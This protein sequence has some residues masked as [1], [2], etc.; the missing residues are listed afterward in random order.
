VLIDPGDRDVVGRRVDRLDRLGGVDRG[1]DDRLV[2]NTAVGVPCDWI[3][4]LV[5]AGLERDDLLEMYGMLSATDKA[6]AAK[7]LKANGIDA[8]K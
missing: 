5:D 1:A 3:P 6:E 7:L 8:P 4:V 2:R